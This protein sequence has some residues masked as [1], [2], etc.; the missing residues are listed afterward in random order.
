MSTALCQLREREIIQSRVKGKLK[1][2]TVMIHAKIKH[3]MLNEYLDLIKVLIKQTT[4]KGCLT[5]SFNQSK[6]E[7]TEFV[8]YEQW[9]NQAALDIHISELF[10]I[11]GPAK[12]GDPIPEKLMN[13]YERATPV[14]YDIVS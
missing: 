9:E 8:L 14:Y 1:V 3:E 13:M 4:R 2:L 12:P 6:D 10:D 11:L 7:P 5:Y